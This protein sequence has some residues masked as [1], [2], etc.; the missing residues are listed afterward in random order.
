MFIISVLQVSPNYLDPVVNATGRVAALS[1][2][3]SGLSLHPPLEG[4]LLLSALYRAFQV[5]SAA[6]VC[7]GPRML[8]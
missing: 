4:C 5:M 8:R 1:E 6:Y 2:Y 7:D 3:S